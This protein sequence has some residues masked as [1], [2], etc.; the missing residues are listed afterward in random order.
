MNRWRGAATRRYARLV[1]DAV[2]RWPPLWRLL[3][4]PLR[5]RFD[6]LAPHWD[7]I[8]RPGGLAPLESALADLSPPRNA[9]DL[10]TGTGDAAVLVARRF[11]EAE[12]VGVDVAPAMVEE[13]RRKLPPDL[14]GRLRF[15][16]ADAARLPFRDGEFE[17]VT[18]ANMIPFWDELARVVAPG[19]A[20]AIS[21]GA[22]P[23]TPIYVAPGRLRA[24]LGRR[25]FSQFAEITAGAG[26][27]LLARRQEA[28]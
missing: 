1:T 16:V 8:R 23:S 13:A 5:W 18:L 4:R 14:A 7:R 22:G 9:L 6:R 20:L 25:G 19:G 15:A 12:V 3:G 10:G 24:E 26:T 27:A 17:L 21:F 11:P 2:T 28:S